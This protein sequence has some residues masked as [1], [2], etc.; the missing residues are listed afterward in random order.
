MNEESSIPRTERERLSSA[1]SNLREMAC[2]VHSGV[3]LG[4]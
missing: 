3:A 4:K 2:E 1:E